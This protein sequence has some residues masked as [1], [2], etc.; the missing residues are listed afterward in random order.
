MTNREKFKELFGFDIGEVF[1]SPD[2]M[3]AWMQRDYRTPN[4]LWLR[5]HS[6]GDGEVEDN[7]VCPYCISKMKWSQRSNYCPNCGKKLS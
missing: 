1:L 3:L 6:T 2:K 4:S 5:E 7:A